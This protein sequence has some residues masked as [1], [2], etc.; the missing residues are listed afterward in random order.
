M[1]DLRIFEDQYSL[2]DMIIIDNCV[3]S[4]SY[5]LDNGIPCINFR[6]DPEDDQLLKLVDYMPIL[7][8]RSDVRSR[9]KSLFKL[10]E[11]STT[12]EKDI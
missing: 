1:K 2:E 7:A 4:F 11:L 9:I 3:Y 5:Q 8:D 10:S 12:L 6:D